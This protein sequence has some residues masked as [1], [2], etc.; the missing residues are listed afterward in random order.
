MTKKLPTIISQEEFE[1]LF[2]NAKKIRENSHKKRKK[3]INQYM[4]AML[5]G[6]EAG[7]RLSEIVGLPGR[8]KPLQKSQV[9]NSSI[10]II[11]GKGEKDRI[12]PRPKRFNQ[13]AIN[14]LPLKISRRALQNFTTYLGKLVL[15]KR[16]TF[17]TLR[18]GFATHYYN[19]TKDLRGLQVLLGHSRLDTTQIYAHVD[20]Q[21]LLK[22]AE[23]V[24]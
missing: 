5:L 17:H 3:I 15:K 4:I 13:K 22:R 16:I 11:S 7:M 9:S 10:K 2:S 12:V 21:E 23:E 19:K 1:L 18:H 24:F 8:I 6:F 14:E 20:P